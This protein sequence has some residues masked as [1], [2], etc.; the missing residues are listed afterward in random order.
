M[1][2]GMGNCPTLHCRAGDSVLRND[3]ERHGQGLSN[4]QHHLD[5]LEHGRSQARWIAWN[6]EQL[7]VSPRKV[8]A[9]CE[10]EP[11]LAKAPPLAARCKAP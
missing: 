1:P 11:K 4:E 5:A 9:A 3:R 6:E 2:S 7:P 10:P 8:V